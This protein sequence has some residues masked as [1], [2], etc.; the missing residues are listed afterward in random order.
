MSE[1][2]KDNYNEDFH[3]PNKQRWYIWV[4]EKVTEISSGVK[5]R[6]AG[7]TNPVRNDADITLWRN[8]PS[9]WK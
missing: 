7:Y 9:A 6:V 4:E 2:S 8:I 1:I 3:W 5:S